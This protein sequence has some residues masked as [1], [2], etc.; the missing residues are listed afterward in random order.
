MKP[1]PDPGSEGWHMSLLTHFPAG[2]GVDCGFIGS[3]PGYVR[4]WHMSLLTHF[5][6]GRGVDHGFIGINPVDKFP[7]REGG[8][9]CLY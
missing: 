8:G 4:G 6:T 1:I 3:N 7:G 5:P 9:M 2:R